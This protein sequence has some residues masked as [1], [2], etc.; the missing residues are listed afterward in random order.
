MACQVNRRGRPKCNITN[1][2]DHPNDKFCATCN[3]R[4]SESNSWQVI[5]FL[6]A[7]LI[8]LIMISVNH[9]QKSSNSNLI[10][11]ETIYI[12]SK[13]IVQNDSR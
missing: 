4:F 3:Q 10:R 13:W 6:I 9:V 2:P 7:L 5:G 8:A 11:R 1:H 12:K